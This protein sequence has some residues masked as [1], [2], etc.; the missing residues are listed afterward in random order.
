MYQSGPKGIQMDIAHKLLQ[1]DIFL[2]KDRLVTV[3]EKMPMATITSVE[4]HG[5]PR[6]ELPHQAGDGNCSCSEKKMSMIAKQRP[7]VARGRAS[8]QDSAQ[9]IKEG[10]AIFI[11]SKD[12]SPVDPSDHHMV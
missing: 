9:S 6:Q 11:V 2:A 3:L 8:H 7:C 12:H 10:L 1:V 5:I 4:G